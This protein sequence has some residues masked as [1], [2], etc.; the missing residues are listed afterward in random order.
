MF[1]AGYSPARPLAKSSPLTV[2]PPHAC[3]AFS[4]EP[5]FFTSHRPYA[6]SRNGITPAGIVPYGLNV[7]KK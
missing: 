2:V 4:S 7:Q 5:Y 6:F 1:H 3:R